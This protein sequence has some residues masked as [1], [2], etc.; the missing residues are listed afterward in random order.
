MDVGEGGGY[1]ATL[2]NAKKSENDAA[3]IKYG[4]GD[5]GRALERGG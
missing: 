3:A 5:E 2:E 4:E 1:Q